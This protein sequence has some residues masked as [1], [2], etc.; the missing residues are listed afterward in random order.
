MTYAQLLEALE[1]VKRLNPELLEL[2]VSAEY[3]YG[4]YGRTRA[5]SKIEDLRI[6]PITQSAYSS[7]GLAIDKIDEV[8]E[9]DDF[10]STLDFVEAT[11]A[12]AEEVNESKFGLVLV[13]APEDERWMVVSQW[14]I[15]NG[16]QFGTHIKRA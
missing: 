9:A 5:I 1:D 8:P 4:D 10:A 16:S 11:A 3:N 14:E 13:N 6:V 12:W 2:P 15:V 7:S